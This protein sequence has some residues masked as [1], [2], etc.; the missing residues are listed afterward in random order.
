MAQTG[1]LKSQGQPEYAAQMPVSKIN[2]RE[3]E[4]ERQRK[5]DTGRAGYETEGSSL[6]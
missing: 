2:Q 3:R 1:G 6:W 4:T 5:R